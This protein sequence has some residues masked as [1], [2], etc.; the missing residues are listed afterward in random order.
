M[1]YSNK[2]IVAVKSNGKVLREF[3]GNEVRLPF[4]SDYTLLL[5]NKDITRK[6]LVTVKVDGKDVMDGKSLVLNPDSATELKGF[7]KGT[8]VR[9]KFRFIEKTKTISEYRG[10]NEE[11]GLI[12]VVY[13]FEKEVLPLINQNQFWSNYWQFP[14]TYRTMSNSS[15]SLDI[16][17]RCSVNDSGITVPGALT[18]QEFTKGF[19][20]ESDGFP[21]NIIIHLK[22]QV[23]D[24]VSNKSK[25]VSKPITVKSK[26]ICSTCGKTWTNDMIYCGRCST[27][28]H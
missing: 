2:F 22:G 23:K 21:K 18:N 26:V 16:V 7:I 11:D 27:Y 10:D 25:T 19:F 12:E 6:V 20:G 15:A 5:K 24:V 17:C 9:N 8:S 4:G 14:P 1:V 28:L 13:V 3:N